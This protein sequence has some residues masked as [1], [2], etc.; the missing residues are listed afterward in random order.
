MSDF[1]DNFSDLD[2]L[3]SVPTRATKATTLETIPCPKCSGHGRIRYGYVNIQWFPCTMCKGEK[4]VTQARINRFNGA[5]KAE[6][7][8][9]ENLSNK[10]NLFR[11]EHPKVIEW[12]EKNIGYSEFAKSLNDALYAYGRL[13]ENQVTAVYRSIEKSQ[14]RMKAAEASRSVSLDSNATKIHET[15]S[16]ALASGLKNP[17]LRVDQ[18]KF[19]LAKPGSK[20]PGCVYVSAGEYVGKISPEGVFVPT[21]DCPQ[22]VKTQVLEIAKDPLTAAVAY[23]K[24]TGICSCC[25]RE[26]TDS[27]SIAMGIGPICAEKYFG[28]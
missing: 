8:R 24:K 19:T 4:K 16:K 1:I 22:E 28:G 15:L 23:G 20:N 10:I 3:D 17:S 12:L 13:T 5:K 14:E 6:S 25:G 27:E 9:K 7:T 11:E 2:D 18:V 21:R 26:L